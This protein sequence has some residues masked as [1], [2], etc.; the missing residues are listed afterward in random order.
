MNKRIRKLTV[1]CF[2]AFLFCGFFVPI[3]M[4]Q[5][6]D[7]GTMSVVAEAGEDRNVIVGRQMIFSATT[8]IVKNI[9]NPNYRWDLGDG[10]VLLGDEVSHIYYNS[11]VYRVKLDVSAY[12]DG[13]KISSRDEIIVNVDKD[14]LVLISDQAV[15]EEKLNEVQNMAS[16]Q[17]ILI[18]NINES[19]GSADY[20]TEKELAQKIIKNK[21][22]LLQA[23]SIVVWT[24]KNIGLNAFLE[25]AQIL[26][27][28]ASEPGKLGFSNKIITVITDQNFSAVGRVSQNLYDILEPQFIVLSDENATP[29]VFSEVKIDELMESLRN[30]E[31]DSHLVGLHTKREVTGFQGWNFLSY[32]VSFMVNRGVPLN[33][34][35]LILVLPI[36]ATVIAFFRQVIGIKALGI[37]APS[38]IAVSFLA[39]GL[40]YGLIIFGITLLVGTVGRLTAKKFR[41]SYLPRMANV[42]IAVCL[43]IFVLF[44]FGAFFEKKGLMEISIFPILIMV[45]LTEKFIAV[46]IE[47]GSKNAAILVVETLILSIL[48]FWLAN[49]HTLKTFILAYPEFILLTLIINIVLGKWTGIRLL[50]LYRF[51]K[52]IKN[53]ELDE[54]K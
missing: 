4:A 26:S 10:T 33:T 25:A 28:T 37:Y 8:S 15:D 48:C 16:S 41:L 11:G 7:D 12:V 13:E 35:Y 9:E 36:I 51:R 52:V 22:D 30:N 45:L 53:V 3:V 14:V 27:K 2:V 17:G 39:T 18:V 29:Y 34:I 31:I 21:E 42:L 38:I 24:E 47:R 6:L 49:W 19:E 46:Q 44:L 20:V 50:E 54:K 23:S 1:I 43:I 5:E 40:R 32:L